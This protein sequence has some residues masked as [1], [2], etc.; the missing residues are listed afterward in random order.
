MN[1]SLKSILLFTTI[2]LFSFS[3]AFSQKSCCAKGSKEEINCASKS[4]STSQTACCSGATAAKET[5]SGCTPSNCRGAK[6]KFG[7]ARVISN[8]RLELVSLKA[9]LENHNDYSFSEHA[10]SVHDIIGETDEH[11]LEII[12]EHVALIE[13]E[14]LPV[15]DNE[16]QLV[17]WSENKA[18]KVKQLDERIKALNKLL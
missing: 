2:I 17:E 3:E 5:T 14:I 13:S 16:L 6:T 7:E 18:I 15:K 4:N 11:S 8:L 12:T 9:K 1:F 10:I